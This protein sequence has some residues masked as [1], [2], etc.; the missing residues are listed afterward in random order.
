MAD[1]A[2]EVVEEIQEGADEVELES[3]R[4]VAEAKAEGRA[5][6]A[7][8]NGGSTRQ[9]TTRSSVRTVVV[10]DDEE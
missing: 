2:K 9:R 8:V 6:A 7:A 3:E 1:G 4:L 5:A 10:S